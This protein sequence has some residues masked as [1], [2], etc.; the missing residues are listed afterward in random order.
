MAMQ[1]RRLSWG[2]LNEPEMSLRAGKEG[3]QPG[4]GGRS[5]LEPS[6]LV[7]HGHHPLTMREELRLLRSF[8]DAL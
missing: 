8:A 5:V 2:M 4:R 1:E 6:L 3:G 7:C